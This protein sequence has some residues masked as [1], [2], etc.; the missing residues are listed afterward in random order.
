MSGTAVVTEEQLRQFYE[1]AETAEKLAEALKKQIN[2]VK[3]QQGTITT[4]FGHK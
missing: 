1:R 4:K 3:S 2:A